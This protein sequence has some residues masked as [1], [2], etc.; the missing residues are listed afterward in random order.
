MNRRHLLKALFAV[1]VAAVAAP[2]AAALAP[3]P[4]RFAEGGI[5][6]NHYPCIVGEH[7][8][9]LPVSIKPATSHNVGTLAVEVHCDTSQLEKNLEAVRNTIRNAIRRNA[10]RNPF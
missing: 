6:S 8:C 1:P 9:E 3:K 5:I 7:C 4:N 2:I 10:M